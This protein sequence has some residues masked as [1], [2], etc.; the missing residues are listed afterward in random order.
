MWMIFARREWRK[1][2]GRSYGRV[3]CCFLRVG[4]LRFFRFL[5]SNFFGYKNGG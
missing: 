3:S 1:I 5:G 2:V 4:G